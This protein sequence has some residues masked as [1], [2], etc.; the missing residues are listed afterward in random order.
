LNEE[1]LY[2]CCGMKPDL[3]QR[4]QDDVERDMEVVNI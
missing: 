2:D 4:L 1:R 3:T